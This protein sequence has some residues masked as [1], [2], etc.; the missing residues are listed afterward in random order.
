MRSGTANRLL[1]KYRQG[2]MHLTALNR[3]V[4][5]FIDAHPYRLEGH[6]SPDHM[7]YVFTVHDV[8]PVPESISLL[9]GDV[10]HNFRAC[11]DHL[12]WAISTSPDS[13][14]SFPILTSRPS[15]G[16]PQKAKEFSAR[17]QA[18]ACSV[19]PDQTDPQNPELAPL[20]ILRKLDNI[21]KHQVI[22]T[23]VSAV[24]ANFHGE[25]SSYRGKR[26]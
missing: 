20:E 23:G 17:H 6:L 5:E 14:T 22:L 19:Q 18:V 21:D 16:I 1:A 9:A 4:K 25:P 26:P 10:I 24:D 2:E 3:I 15:D 7:E 8:Q 12:A 11:L 13:N